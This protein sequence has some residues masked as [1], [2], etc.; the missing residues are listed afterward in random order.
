MMKTFNFLPGNFLAFY[1]LLIATAALGQ[2]ADFRPVVR[3][4][5]KKGERRIVIAP[6]VYRLAPEAGQGTIWTV[7]GAQDVEIIADGVTLVGTKLTRAV[8]LEN[9]RNMTLQGLTVD[10]DPLPF[11]QGTVTAAAPD[12]SWI[13]IK[14]HDGYPRQ[15]YA[16]IDVVDPQTRFRKKGMPF[17]WGTKAEM[18]APDTVRVTLK[19]IGNAAAFGDYASLSTG[20]EAG[21]PPHGLTVENCAGTTLNN[22]TVHCA[23][24]MGILEVDGEGRA[25][26]QGCKIVRGPKPPGATQERLLTTSWDAMQSKTIKYGPLV[27]NCVIED[28]GDDSWSVQSSDF[29]VVKRER[30]NITIATRDEWTDGVQVGDRLRTSLDGPEVK[31]TARKVVKREAANLAPETL[32][33]LKAAPAYSLWNVSPKCFELTIDRESPFKVGDSVYSPDRQ[34]N[35][36]KFANNKIH[37]PGR[38]LIKAGG[39]GLV[40]NNEFDTPHNITICPEIPG[41]AAAGIKGLIIRN[42]TIRSAGYFCPAP[43]S[44]A[45]G[46]LSITASSKPPHLRPAGVFDGILIEGNIFENCNGPNLVLSSVRNVI[47]R[48]NKYVN[49]QQTKPNDTGA[50]YGIAANSVVWISQSEGVQIQ[51][52]A[53]AN[54]GRFAGQPIVIMPDAKVQLLK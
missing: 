44:S 9:C 41:E 49:A 23:P 7:R 3:E 35:G 33:K 45:A 27:E 37:S 30:N 6:G 29:L 34:G 16:R 24:G 20:S 51:R 26:F 40:A 47:V 1:L 17:L 53:A 36:F 31:I 28:A 54:I 14:I 48:D 22:V 12:K 18:S 32:E 46:A 38:L 43:W 15:P 52:D 4:A 21:L 50:V 13:D 8:A 5:L 42:N 39:L 25:R 19:G 11:T 2:P 10:Y